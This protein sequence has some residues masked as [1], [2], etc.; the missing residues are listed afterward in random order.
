[1]SATLV[2]EKGVD[3]ALRKLIWVIVL[4]LLAPALDTTI[5][6]V[7]LATIGTAMHTS[8]ATSQWT[9]TGYLLAMGMAMPVSVWAAERFGGKNVWL[10]SLAL[11]AAFSAL[12]V[13]G[14]LALRGVPYARVRRTMTGRWS[15]PAIGRTVA[16]ATVSGPLT[17]TWS[18]WL[19]GR[20]AGHVA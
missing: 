10:S 2:P 12:S 6:N 5:V 9:I 18:T 17:R 1:M 3:P 7:A 16:P 4:G 20:Q 15:E 14:R 8:V 13:G 11:F 19:W